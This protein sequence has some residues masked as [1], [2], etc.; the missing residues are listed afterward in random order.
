LRSSL[1]SNNSTGYEADFIISPTTNCGAQNVRW[2]GAVGNFTVLGNT[3]MTCPVTGDTFTT[4]MIGTTMKIYSNGIP[5]L[6]STDATY[7]S[8]KPGMGQYLF[9]PGVAGTDFGQTSMR[10]TDKPL[11]S[12]AHTSKDNTSTAVALTA[13]NTTGATEI[14]VVVFWNSTTRTVTCTGST[15]GSLSA[16]TGPT[17]ITGLSS[18]RMEIFHKDNPTVGASDAITCTLSGSGNIDIGAAASAIMGVSAV[19]QA[20]AIHVATAATAAATTTSTTTAVDEYLIGACVLGG[21]LTLGSQTAQFSLLENTN[22]GGN[23]FY[24]GISVKLQTIAF[25]VSQGAS[26]PYGCWA[27]TFK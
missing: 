26:N 13:M 27:G 1:A 2:N 11:H 20:P 3:A 7:A 8:G 5:L 15:S 25:S 17:T 21:N 14:V 4:T 24:D 18:Y 10:F 22:F 6:T 16:I 12:V 9:G 23:A 19:D